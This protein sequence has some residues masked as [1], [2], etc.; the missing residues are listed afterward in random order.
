MVKSSRDTIVSSLNELLESS[1][2]RPYLFRTRFERNMLRILNYANEVGNTALYD[3]AN[4]SLNKMKF[5]SDKSNT[6]SC[7][8]LRS[9]VLL[10]DDMRQILALV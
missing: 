3:A 10:E 1:T 8:M 4:K 9:Y 5:I 2:I 6:T 7:G